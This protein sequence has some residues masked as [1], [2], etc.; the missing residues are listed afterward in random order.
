MG[1][2]VRLENRDGKAV[3]EIPDLESLLSRF[4]PSWDDLTYH[5][6]RYIDPWGETVFNHLQMDELIFELRA[7]GR[8][9]TPKSNVRLWMRLKAWLDAAKTAKG[10]T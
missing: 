2:S 7:S 4:F 9:Q 8:K 10:Y 5:F 1:M 3:E 6:L